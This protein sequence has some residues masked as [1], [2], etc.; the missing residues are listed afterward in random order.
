MALPHH[1]SVIDDDAFIGRTLALNSTQGRIRVS[2]AAVG[3][4]ALVTRPCSPR[5]LHRQVREPVGERT[6]SE[7]TA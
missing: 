5:T 4:S 1:L 3:T 7:E 2:T 6:A